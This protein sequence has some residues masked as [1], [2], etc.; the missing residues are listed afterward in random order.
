MKA[1]S[2]FCWIYAV[3][4]V[5]CGHL[6]AS[7]V[8]VVEDSV[9]FATDVAPLLQRKCIECH[10]ASL[11]MA[12]LR[13]DTRAAMVDAGVLVPGDAEN[14]LL[15][16]RLH[17]RGLGILMPPTGKLEQ[18]EIETVT[19][20]V[21][22]GANWPA[23]TKLT[24][25]Q[26]SSKEI[27][28]EQPIFA[29]IRHGDDDAIREMLRDTAQI[30]AKN[31][32]G[33]TPL[34]HATLYAS[35][36][37]VKLLLDHGADPNA[38]DNDG[39]TALML[40]VSNL[41]KVRLLLEHGAQVDAKSKLGRTPLLMASAYAG[42]AGVVR[43]L[44]DAGADIH[45][46]DGAGWTS[47]AVAARTGDPELLQTLLASGADVAAGK[48]GPL[49]PGTPLTHAAWL[50]DAESV[51]LLLSHGADKDV[52]SMNVALIFSATHGYQELVQRLLDAG[53]D[54]RANI[55]TNYV[56]ESPILAAAYS[57]SLN[58]EIVK[59][60]LQRGV[61]VEAKDAR[62]ETPLRIARD[63]GQTEIV[64]LLSQSGGDFAGVET[65][66]DRQPSGD[67]PL[68][69]DSI[70]ELARASVSL[71]QSSGPQF[72]SKSGCTACH[73]QTATSL[74]VRMA[75]DRGIDV[76]QTL[77]RQQ[78]KLTSTELGSR[79]A[80]FLQRVKI[81]GS[82]H[83]LGYLLWGMAAADYPPDEITD[84]AYVELAGLQLRNGSWVSDAH[85][86]PTEYSAITATAVA[87]RSLQ[88][89]APPGLHNEASE[90]VARATRWLANAR[91]SA[92]AEKAFRLLGL[93]WGGAAE[94]HL[95]QATQVLL[96]EQS[97]DGGWSQ[98]PALEPDA[99]ATGLTLYALHEAGGLPVDTAA[100]R[101]GVQFLLKT[102]QD[103]GS[104]HVRSRS[105]KFQP[106]FESGFPHGHDQW[107]SAA[108]TGWA[109]MALL[110]T[111]VP[112][113]PDPSPSK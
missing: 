9:D 5:S 101:R 106:Y 67:A 7:E 77:E 41:A 23:D 18:S 1:H 94:T 72:Y 34:M 46:A 28:R 86:P 57:D 49:S 112:G 80:R 97:S 89:Y 22:A 104:W 30:Q 105:F 62:G 61:D 56:P 93:A 74:V 38:T 60:L 43:A 66:S 52:K 31:Q 36:E 100:Y 58:T 12:E 83:R 78:I 55:V 85:R 70:R 103:D 98:L 32:H 3:H 87:L 76:D 4:L 17:D 8:Q 2:I 96:D 20:W 45:Y 91:A 113:S 92:N 59:L 16:Q 29:V 71:L 14:S 37:S 51:E 47:I 109:T 42:N 107:I 64:R 69:S 73:Q 65:A 68:G 21:N 6:F 19:N 82:T 10:D 63:R 81:G 35:P 11:Q 40:A 84:A 39:L 54:P 27:D 95:S 99:Y 25:Q 110:Q 75:R 50:G 48:A 111:I 79:A 53:A 33:A 26:I 102:R 88:H 90:R 15:V 24:P 44:L 108:G 13:L